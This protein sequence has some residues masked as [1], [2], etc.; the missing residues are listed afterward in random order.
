MGDS[1]LYIKHLGCYQSQD[2]QR[3]KY[4]WLKQFW[5]VKA[6]SQQKKNMSN[7]K[8]DVCKIS[9]DI[10]KLRIILTF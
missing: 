8:K 6:T 4:P 5:K 9:L 7:Y 3:L 2:S 1:S 10:Y